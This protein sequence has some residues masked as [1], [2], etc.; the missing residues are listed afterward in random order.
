MCVVS[1]DILPTLDRKELAEQL[2]YAP[3]ANVVIFTGNEIKIHRGGAKTSSLLPAGVAASVRRVHRESVY[4][5]DLEMM[6]VEFDN[7][8]FATLFLQSTTRT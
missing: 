1:G 4:D 5:R 7:G 8:R 3:E 6:R 2:N